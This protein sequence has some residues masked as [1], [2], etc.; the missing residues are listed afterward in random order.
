MN[1]SLST[2][3]WGEA[4]GEALAGWA[5]KTWELGLTTVELEYRR[6]A[7]S[8]SHLRQALA[9]YGLGVS[10]LHAPFP[11]PEVEGDPLQLADLAAEEAEARR[12]AEGLVARTLEEAVRWGAGVVVLHSGNIR[13]LR[14]LEQR[15]R[16][17]YLAG[18]RDGEF[19]RLWEELRRARQIEAPRHLEWVREALGRLSVRARELGVVIALENRADYRD[20]P[21]PEE[22]GMLL[23]EFGREVGFW[24]DAGHAHRLEVL[25]FY[26]RTLWLERYRERLVG[27]HLHDS[28]GLSDHLPPGMG[29]IPFEQVFSL[30]P[31][32]G[33]RVLEV[34]AGHTPEELARGLARLRA[35]EVAG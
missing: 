28:R 20:I 5:R 35:L 4:E 25:G 24:Y 7:G 26:P 14:P 9:G 29:E 23:A 12:Y 18:R 3:W 16:E 1:V 27:A 17:C 15:L 33:L 31:R 13:R 10:S 21:S 30:L 2:M 19:R 11:H 34:D 22:L 32:Q 6:S 8:L